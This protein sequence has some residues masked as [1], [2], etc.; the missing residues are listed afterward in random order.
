[1]LHIEHNSIL[2]EGSNTTIHFGRKGD[3]TDRQLLWYI[4]WN[5]E[6]RL[7]YVFIV[8][9]GIH[10]CIHEGSLLIASHP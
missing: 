4:K 1:M 3:T 9:V 5:S 7:S 2:C 8:G 10:T 6:Y